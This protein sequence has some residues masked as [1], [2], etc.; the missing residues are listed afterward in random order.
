MYLLMINNIL[1]IIR[2]FKNKKYNNVNN[3]KNKNKKQTKKKKKKKKNK[4]KIK[5]Q[6]K[7]NI[8]YFETLGSRRVIRSYITIIIKCF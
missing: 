3:V 7:N 2:K 6:Y 5:N 1:F 8:K 4:K